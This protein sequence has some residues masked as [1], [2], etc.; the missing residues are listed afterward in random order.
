MI[1]V[2]TSIWVEALRQAQSPAAETLRGLLDADEVA[3]PFPVRLELSSGVT[4]RD[5]ASLKR[6]LSS[7]P[8]M[9]PSDATWR[10][11][12]RW[13]DDAANAGQ[14]FAISDLLIAA[15]ADEIGALVWTRDGDFQRMADLKLVRLYQ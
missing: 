7:L 4:R 1:V 9:L 10:Q 11:L 3:L 8:V 5:R 15:L 14:R 13:I 6:A 2:D 12:E